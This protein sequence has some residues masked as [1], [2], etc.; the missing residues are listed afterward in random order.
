MPGERLDRP[1]PGV[2]RRRAWDRRAGGVTSGA[3]RGTN[4]ARPLLRAYAVVVA[5]VALNDTVNV[6]SVLYDAARRGDHLAAWRPITWEATSGA[7]DLIACFIIYAALRVA[8]PGGRP[9]AIT[10]P[11]HAAASLAFSAVHVSL[12]MGL[13]IAIYGALGLRYGI[14]PG[15][16]AYEYRKDLTAYLVLAGVFYV[17]ASRKAAISGAE[18]APAPPATTIDIVEGARTLRVRPEDVVALKSAGNYVEFHLADG[19]RPLMRATLGDLTERL[20]AYGFERTHR[21]WLVN[22][23]HVRSLEP[24]G[25]GDYSLELDGG[26]EAPLSRRFPTALDRLRRDQQAISP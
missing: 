4:G 18:P 14:E 25:S 15:A 21:S 12:M 1:G 13:R 7:G 3:S 22:A 10:L 20:G 5:L 8:P 23:R 24:A 11:I 16:A 6:L 19:R 26:V 2:W 9:W 17:F